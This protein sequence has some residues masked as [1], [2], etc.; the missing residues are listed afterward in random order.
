MYNFFPITAGNITK[1]T[2][3]NFDKL[4]DKE[5]SNLLAKLNSLLRVNTSSML[6]TRIRA[7]KRI[8]KVEV[9]GDLFSRLLSANRIFNDLS[10][11]LC[12]LNDFDW[13]IVI[14]YKKWIA[15][16]LS[17][18]FEKPKDKDPQED[19][20]QYKAMKEFVADYG[21]VTYKKYGIEWRHIVWQK[22][23]RYPQKKRK[24]H[25]NNI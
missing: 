1:F 20:K 3:T 9:D 8:L 22:E 2:D 25:H 4:N 16:H 19:D 23:F 21:Y 5:K 10:L 11:C 14:N 6:L 15:E 24:K 12:T 13:K 18:D 17:C 7:L